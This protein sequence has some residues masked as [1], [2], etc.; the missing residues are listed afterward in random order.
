MNLQKRAISFFFLVSKV[1]NL[2][3]VLFF[4]I[5]KKKEKKRK[6]LQKKKKS[7]FKSPLSG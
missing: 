5:N 3:N 1:H 4:S 2:L 7:V 6:E